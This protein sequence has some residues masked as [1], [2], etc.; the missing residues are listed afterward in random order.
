MAKQGQERLVRLWVLEKGRCKV[1]GIW[2]DSSA[3]KSLSIGR[4]TID[5][6]S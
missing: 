2:R 1:R 3:L 6:V 4:R 5:E